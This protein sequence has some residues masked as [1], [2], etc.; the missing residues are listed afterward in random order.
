M[1]KKKMKAARL[2]Q[3]YTTCIVGRAWHFQTKFVIVEASINDEQWRRRQQPSGINQQHCTTAA[4]YSDRLL[5]RHLHLH[6]STLL[7]LP[8]SKHL[9]RLS[10]REK[11]SQQ[12]AQLLQRYRA[13]LRVIKYFAKSLKIAQDHCRLKAY[14]VF[15][16]GV[17][18]INLSLISPEHIRYT[19]TGQ[20]VTTFKEFWVRSVHFGQNGGLGRVPRSVKVWDAHQYFR[21]LI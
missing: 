9:Q 8:T 3:R 16:L 18:K 15:I 5:Y 14:I 2:D 21:C 1:K 12:A 7:P 13:M 4:G 17:R 10:H 19:W 20:R 11:L 6:P